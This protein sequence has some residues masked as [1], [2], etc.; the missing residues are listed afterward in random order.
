MKNHQISQKVY[1]NLFY[2]Y[3]LAN[4]ILD[5]EGYII[6]VNKTW[7]ELLGYK[8][9]E[10]IGKIFSIFISPEY[11]DAINKDFAA[12]ISNGGCKDKQVI[13]L[14]KDGHEIH[15]LFNGH[16]E[17]D[18]GG[19]ITQI[20]C[21]FQDITKRI[22][23]ENKLKYHLKYQRLISNISSSFVG[24][25]DLNE[26]INHLLQKIGEFTNACRAYVFR[27]NADEKHLDNTHE[28]CAED[29]DPQIGN[30]KNLKISNMQWSLNKLHKGEAIL[31]KDVSK[32]PKEA[33][34]EKEAFEYQGIKSLVALPIFIFDRLIGFIGFDKV[35]E[36]ITDTKE[37]HQ[38][39]KI[40][41]EILAN[42]IHSTETEERVK[43]SEIQY[44]TLFES[45][46]DGISLIKDGL[47]T[48]CNTKTL[49]MFACRKDDIIGYSPAKL[50]P[51]LQYDGYSS[52]EK[53]PAEI[54]K[55]MN[56]KQHSF[57]WLHKRLDG[58]L[59][60]TEIT[61]SAINISSEN[62]VLAMIRD[63]SERKNTEKTISENQSNLTALIENTANLIWSIDNDYKLIIAN[64]NF[65]KR[66]K[67][68]YGTELKNG[69]S[70]LDKKSISQDLYQSWKTN[71]DT[72]LSGKRFSEE[73]TSTTLEQR[74]Y[75]YTYNPI[76][77]EKGEIKGVSIIGRDITEFKKN[78]QEINKLSA[79][80]NQSSNAIVITDT[81]ANIEYVNQKFTEISD[82]NHEELIGNNPRVLSAGKHD[83]TFYAKLWH[84]IKS[85]EIWE[86]EFHNKTKEGHFY[87]ERASITPL[88][89][90]EGNIVNYLGI[91]QDITERKLLEKHAKQQYLQLEEQN[92]DLEAFSH[93]VA[94]DLK[95]PL[96]R[97]MSFST[98]LVD[99]FDIIHEDEKIQFLKTII[100]GGENAIQ[101]INSLLLFASV[102]KK[103]VKTEPLQ[104][105]AIVKNTIE[106][107]SELKKVKGAAIKAPNKWPE[108][109]G[110]PDWI[111]EAWVNYLSNALK[112]GGEEPQ[113][114]FGY[115][116]IKP[117]ENQKT[118]I[119]FWI[120]DT[121][122]GISVKNQK[123]LFEKFERLEQVNITGHGLG[124]SI[125][126]SIINKL[127]GQVGVESQL[128]KGC[129]FYFT[130][131]TK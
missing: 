95:N 115:N 89:D 121:G 60:D 17:A 104:M 91:K 81:D 5:N 45:A 75:E 31:I 42:S 100:K 124:L 35:D 116:H 109:V 26:S 43:R 11:R 22:E 85:G 58:S 12:N 47:I 51:P 3:P 4:Q 65:L 66:I 56:G 119:R 8:R 107:F 23:T 79:A 127:D 113:I 63:V 50:S 62:Y 69:D 61:L 110:Y 52:T 120:K 2:N 71:Y 25:F 103:N 111:E 93:T 30:L 64:S 20:Y 80:V 78:I 101:I 34:N 9:D 37:F 29:I 7:I 46:G 102:R 82:Y 98:L 32:L 18:E 15:I 108:V 53:A 106:R 49:D 14:H 74:T 68:I 21:I 77:N 48:D 13:L 55:V 99:D 123:L 70:I 112:Y 130:L 122:P 125:V 97:I 92:R 114:E 76:I 87:Y 129:T 73:I 96:A 54:K 6:D 39:L 40:S 57:S 59:F 117:K 128:G 41:S 72:A 38:V 36:Y 94:H 44:R 19:N 27:I 10:V 105:S 67:E 28:W 90:D 16:V 86:G 131:P 84:T 126:K 118:Y 83:K 1:N 88:K 33:S 24:N